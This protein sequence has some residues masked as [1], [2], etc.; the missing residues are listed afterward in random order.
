MSEDILGPGSPTEQFIRKMKRRQKE[1]EDKEWS[2]KGK[3]ICLLYGE[4]LSM[5]DQ[6]GDYLYSEKIIETLRQKLI[7]D[8]IKKEKEIRK[9]FPE[10]NKSSGNLHPSDIEDIINRR[11]GYE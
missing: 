10:S 4:T 2:L 1:S 5:Y 8:I 7:E 9:Q 11:F 3:G 6:K